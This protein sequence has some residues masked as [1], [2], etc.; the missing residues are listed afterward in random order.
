MD[1]EDSEKLKSSKTSKNQSKTGVRSQCQRKLS[2]STSAH[3]EVTL[4]PIRIFGSSQIKMIPCKLAV[5]P[6]RWNVMF[7]MFSKI[8]LQHSYSNNAHLIKP[9]PTFTTPPP[10]LPFW[11]ASTLVV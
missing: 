3:S 6:S 4:V 5:E 9:K 2:E 7:L 11:I 10:Q 8:P 1:E